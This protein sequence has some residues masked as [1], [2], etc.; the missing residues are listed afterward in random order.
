MTGPQ[1]LSDLLGSWTF[2]RWIEDHRAG[3]GIEVVGEATI[4]VSTD[5]ATYDEAGRMALPGQPP[6]QSTR[7]YLLREGGDHLAFHFD[8]GRFFHRWDY[9]LTHPT[10]HHHCPPDSYDV[11]YDTSDWP[12][13]RATWTVSGPRKDYV[14]TTRYTR[15]A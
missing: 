1:T 15:A 2:T 4:T 11:R 6:L 3:Q 9:G 5:G 13:W 10:C 14:M 7:R 12:T 8:D